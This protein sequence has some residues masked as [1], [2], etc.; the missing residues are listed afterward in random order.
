MNNLLMLFIF[1]PILALVLLFLNFLFSVHRP[2]ESKIVVIQLLE[3]KIE[4]I[5]K[6]NF[7]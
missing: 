3:N 7:M 5:S 6:F 4:L 2:D 1:V